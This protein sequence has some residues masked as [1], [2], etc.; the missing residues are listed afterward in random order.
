MESVVS[1]QNNVKSTLVDI[2][3]MAKRNILKIK[4]NPD[5]LIDVTVIPIFFMIVFSYLFGG[6]IAGGVQEYLPIIVPG[7]LIQTLVMSSSATGTQLREDLDT[8]VFDRFKSLPIVRIAPLAGLV[9]SDIL[10]YIMAALFSIGTGFILGWRPEAG[11]GWLIVASLLAIFGACAISWVFALIGLVSKSSATIS[12]VSTMVTMMMSFL[13]NAFV[14]TNTLP[15]FLQ[16]VAEYNPVTYLVTAFKDLANHG[17][18]T[19]SASMTIF[20]GILLVLII[21][22]ITVKIYN[23]KI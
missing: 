11:M 4:H 21:A 22:P 23:R 14:P 18:F 10:R 20:I 9:V 7:I 5:K 15:T 8:G 3:V 2:L 13:S 19:S 6:A 1:K 17:Q 16:R 12:S